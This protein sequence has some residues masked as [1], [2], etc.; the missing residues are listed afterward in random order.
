MGACLAAAAINHGHDVVI[1]SGPVTVSYPEQAEVIHVVTTDEML[2]ASTQQFPSCDGVIS[3]AAPC[4]FQPEVVADQKLK[5]QGDK[6]SL[7]LI[8]TPDILQS[9][10]KS[11][12]PRQ[13]SVAFALE[14]E[15]GIENAVAKLKRKNC[16]LVV[17]NSPSA[18]NSMETHVKIL[19]SNGTMIAEISDSKQTAADTIITCIQN[20]LS[21]SS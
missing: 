11:K 3:A 21:G 6:I 5:K 10:G 8:E 20:Q 1:V 4:D 14:T 18:I 19:D 9:L 2:E 15:N 13:W 12:R 7:K 16:D 17:L